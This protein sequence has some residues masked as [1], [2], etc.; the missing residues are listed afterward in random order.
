MVIVKSLKTKLP[1]KRCFELN[2]QIYI[3]ER[4][5]DY[6]PANSNHPW[7]AALWTLPIVFFVFISVSRIFYREHRLFVMRG[8]LAL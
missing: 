7:L 4:Q 2:S 3:F 6:V 5:R 1:K 8:E